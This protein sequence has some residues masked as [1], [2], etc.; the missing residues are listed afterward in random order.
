[1]RLNITSA[2]WKTLEI[3][4]SDNIIPGPYYRTPAQE[5]A[6]RTEADRAF[7]RLPR[8]P[9]SSPLQRIVR[10]LLY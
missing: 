9:V 8:T 3:D 1:M 6:R 5:S 10:L 7:S 2:Q 4:Y